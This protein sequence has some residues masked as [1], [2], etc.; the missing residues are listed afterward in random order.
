MEEAAV[1]AS[2]TFMILAGIFFFKSMICALR[3]SKV[4]FPSRDHAWSSMFMSLGLLS[5]YSSGM[6]LSLFYGDPIWSKLRWTMFFF[7]ILA[8]L[9]YLAFRF[10][11]AKLREDE[12]DKQD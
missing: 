1:Y 4:S 9:F 12:E 11:H 8:T 3:A 7:L 5:L 10:T 2:L 6:V